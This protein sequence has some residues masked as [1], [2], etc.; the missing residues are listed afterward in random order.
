MFRVRK[1]WWKYNWRK[2]QAT[3]K[4]ICVQQHGF[5]RT[6]QVSNC[7]RFFAVRALPLVARWRVHCNRFTRPSCAHCWARS[8]RSSISMVWLPLPV[9]VWMRAHSKLDACVRNS[10]SPNPVFDS[11]YR[12]W[13]RHDLLFLS[14]SCSE[15]SR[16][17]DSFSTRWTCSGPEKNL[18]RCMHSDI[19]R[20]STFAESSGGFASV[21]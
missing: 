3:L 12:P 8:H 10:E 14:H 1:I 7:K 17:L 20:M 9:A 5:M 2:S 13:P 15:C 18:V 19:K 21:R 11:W 16:N 6:V 4:P